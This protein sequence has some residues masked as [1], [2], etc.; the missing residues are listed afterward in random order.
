MNDEFFIDDDVI[1]SL[2]DNMIEEVIPQVSVIEQKLKD[3][4]ILRLNNDQINAAIINLI[5]DRY[6]NSSLLKQK[7][8]NYARLFF[9]FPH[10]Q[11]IYFKALRPI[12]S[13]NKLTYFSNDEEYSQNKE[14][15]QAHFEKSDK[16]GNFLN[17]FHSLS[18]TNKEPYSKVVNKLYA[19]YTPF[20][21]IG[22]TINYQ[23]EHEV[24]A[25]TQCLFEEECNA[26]KHSSYRLVSKVMNGKSTVYDGDNVNV[27]GFFNIPH[28]G[29]GDIDKV[30]IVD[31]DQ[32]I[33]NINGL[34]E[35]DK[36]T[37]CFNISTFD[38]SRKNLVHEI[39]GTVLK[40]SATTLTLVLSKE[41]YMNGKLTSELTY[42]RGS[43]ISSILVSPFYVYPHKKDLFCFSKPLLAK[44]HIIFKA[45]VHTNINDVRGFITPNDID[46]LL[47]LFKDRFD[48][49]KNLHDLSTI[50]LLPHGVNIDNIGTNMYDILAHIFAQK[51]KSKDHEKPVKPREELPYRNTTPL[52]DFKKNAKFLDVYSKDYPSYNTYIDDAL[53]RFRYL[54]SQQDSGAYYFLSSLQANM[55]HKYKKHITKLA[56]Y[57][58]ELLIADKA[59]DALEFKDDKQKG[60]V[61]ETC[62][63]G[64]YAKEYKKIDKLS[65]DNN[66]T[67]Y[68][69][70]KFDPTPYDVKSNYTGN[71]SKGLHL[72]VMNE[73]LSI[74]KFKKMSKNDLEFEIETVILGKRRIRIGDMCV[75]TTNY[76][77]TV[78]TR[79]TVGD[80]EMWVK[81]FR[82]PFKVCTDSPLV[83]FNDLVKVDTCIKQTFDQVCRTNQ[84][85]HI[86]YK[87]RVLESVKLELT[88]IISLLERYDEVVDI[89][90]HDVKHY[91]SLASILP[92][93]H[94]GK[95]QFEY[96]E[97]VNYD[98][99]IGEQGEVGDVEYTLDFVDQTN[100]SYAIE[101]MT[102]EKDTKEDTEKDINMDSLKMFLAFIQVPLEPMEM[103]FIVNSI[104]SKFPQKTIV[105]QLQ[106]YE[107][108]LMTQVNK[109]AYK[110][111]EKYMKMFDAV[112]KQKVNKKESE[113][114]AKYYYN[115]FCHII[116]FIVII[117]FIRHPMYMMNNVLQ[118]C[119][120]VLGY[121]GYPI[122]K[123]DEQR[124]LTAYFACLL[125]NIS[126]KDDIRFSLF[127]EKSTSEI[128]SAL[129]DTI[130]EIL[131]G[132]YELKSQLEIAKGVISTMTKHSQPVT[133]VHSSLIPH[134]FTEMQGFKP[135]FKFSN[136]ERMSK[137][138]KVILKFLK[139]IKDNIAR[140]KISK[141]NSFNIPSVF[142]T[143]C[144][145][146]LQR[147]VNFY[148]FFEDSNEYTS[149]KKSVETVMQPT[150]FVDENLHPSLNYKSTI[151]LFES[152]N[153]THDKSN[154][155]DV[156]HIDTKDTQTESKEKEVEKISAF[157]QAN[158]DFTELFKSQVLSEMLQ[159]FS[160]ENWWFDTLYPKLGD[161]FSELINALNK[162]SDNGL[163]IDVEAIEYVRNVI[164]NVNSGDNVSSVRQTLYTF[165][166]SRLK[167]TLGKVVNKQKLNITNDEINEE[168]LRANPLFAIIASAANNKN[169]E[170][171]LQNIR[172][173]TLTLK[174]PS[175]MLF[176]AHTD[177][178]VI[179]NISLMA[180]VLIKLFNTILYSAY[181]A[182]TSSLLEV[183]IG[184]V[185]ND[186]KTRERLQFAASIVNYSI[187]SLV[188]ML[189]NTLV[190]VQFLNSEVEKLREQR[191]QELIALY[192][193]DDEERSL[194]MQ[195]KKIGVQ[196]WA[197]ILNNDD[198][199]KSEEQMIAENPPV[200]PAPKDEYEVEKDY[201]Y[202]VY[203]GDNADDDIEEDEFVSLEA[204]DD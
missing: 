104:N 31:I 75:L 98:D 204:Y 136:I 3:D 155:S 102:N 53:N 111:S 114:M 64:S 23:I 192:K 7:V 48:E 200:N 160:S 39:N 203:K 35:G 80:Q 147:D 37:I 40:L 178:L 66:K 145:E 67:L 92:W 109:E 43:N 2:D 182:K 165:I 146:V 138:N 15:E 29:D 52:V 17:K 174:Q 201:I 73:L 120:K 153:I 180:F 186:V 95:R 172:E 8:R 108:A 90:E 84:N 47:M 137:K 51:R 78:Y 125:T 42:G 20:S 32:Y 139:S 83:A 123:K 94:G 88:A 50:V 162:V 198:G 56:Q 197:D 18:T 49:I 11:H 119:V 30:Q 76:G 55:K 130:D 190:D 142:N 150:S 167:Q 60:L 124:S 177:D 129:H 86:H 193:T 25:F 68:F 62:E 122:S 38:K 79:Q 9:T 41:V 96:I 188:T 72:H 10:V 33:H 143:C 191:K 57:H 141:M 121:L 202:S 152:L 161:E 195:L 175:F 194:Q 132:S 106:Q 135:S 5:S 16:L 1:I 199:I 169:F 176:D 171:V 77:D 113:L 148:K 34:V 89:I 128:Q 44:E 82:T 140:S 173:T 69:D 156:G 21:P 116:A 127:Y 61:T 183:N 45:G 85:A 170:L 151:D 27:I 91:H 131:Q 196:N 93:E 179:K 6:R 74:P 103:T 12:I 133:S 181:S 134:E 126:V 163:K 63:S 154:V 107:T 4:S 36:V 54:K 110:T 97:H 24:D 19:L 168:T 13:T 99:Y 22:A 187:Q 26:P 105:N 118:N 112:V 100:F 14:Y 189:K 117:M 81:K 144:A 164:I 65:E 185:S 71:S 157:L 46:E 159:H 87:Y 28:T 59:I 58:R 70:K 166:S 115:V 101:N 184:V 158:K 149:A